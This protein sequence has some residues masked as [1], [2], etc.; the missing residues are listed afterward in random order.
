MKR[1]T[2][3]QFLW[4]VDASTTGTYARTDVHYL[5][6]HSLTDVTAWLQKQY[7]FQELAPESVRIGRATIVEGER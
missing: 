3:P 6:A 4:R 1:N 7:R 2:E 5:V